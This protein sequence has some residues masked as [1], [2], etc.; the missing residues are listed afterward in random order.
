MTVNH[1]LV[2]SAF[3]SLGSSPDVAQRIFNWVSE[4]RPK[5]L[6]SKVYNF[7]CGIL[8]SNGYVNEFWGLVD[9]MKSKGYGVKKGTYDRVWERFEKDELGSDLEKLKRLYDSGSV[10]TSAEKVCSRVSNVIRGQVWGDEVEKELKE[11]SELKGAFDSDV[12]AMVLG[13]LKSEPNKGLIFFRWIEESKLFKHDEATYN[14]MALVLTR[15]DCIDKFW[16][17]VSE[18]RVAGF[19]LKKENYIK[20]LGKFIKRRMIK[21]AVNL[22]EFAMCGET[23]PAVP[24]CTLL[25]RKIVATKELDINLFEKAI[26]AF[27]QG[28]NILTNPILDAV[29]KSLT[30]VGRIGECNKILKAMGEVGYFPSEGLQKKLAFMLS[31]KSK[32]ETAAEFMDYI[33]SHGSKNSKI[34]VSL[35]EGHFARGNLVEATNCFHTMVEKDGAN[36]ASYALDM[37][38]NLYSR[39]NRAIDAYKLLHDMVNENGL[40]P[41]HSTYKV[42][43]SKLLVQGRFKQSLNLLGLMKNQ[44]FPPF[45][46]PIIEYVSKNGTADEAMA[47]LSAMTVKKVPSTTVFVRVFEGYLKAG[48]HSEAQNLLSKCPRLMRDHADVLNLFFAMK[49]N[50]ETA[51]ISVAA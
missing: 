11:F 6:S 17:V 46:E 23:K 28:G 44:G 12:I 4:T 29:I 27:T 20:I 14:A 5:L 22:Y 39:H 3:K 45:L 48:R 50:V 9:V 37:L 2:L 25:L 8:G 41:W 30:S 18:M 36:G 7:M 31:Y 49:P 42:L 38:V 13:K 26:K 15:E 32:K 33:E 10:D 47:F 35:V 1:D 34:W 43:I 24:D 16:K 51:E 40:N 21:D 19:D